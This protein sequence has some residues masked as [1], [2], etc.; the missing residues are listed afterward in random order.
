[1]EIV[2]SKDGTGIAFDRAAGDGPPVVLVGGAFSYRRFKRLREL[3]GLLSD[4]FTVVNYD[5]R[6]RGDSGDTEPYAVE[7]EIE[8]LQVVIDAVGGSASVWGWSSGGVLPLRAAAHGVR[9]EKLAVYEPPSWSLRATACR[10]PTSRGGS[11]T[12]WRG[13]AGAPP[14]GTS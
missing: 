4:D 3:A 6:R 14:S 9:I 1:M 5:R 10:R 13:A 8:D 2:R 12:S 11:T 7:R